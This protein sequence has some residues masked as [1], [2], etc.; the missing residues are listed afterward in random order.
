M[1]RLPPPQVAR[2]QLRRN[3]KRQKMALMAPGTFKRD[4]LG[5][6]GNIATVITSILV[7]IVVAGAE[8]VRNIPKIPDVAYATFND[9]L[10]QREFDRNLTGKWTTRIPERPGAPAFEMI[11]EMETREGQ[12][13]AMMTTHASIPWSHSEFTDVK[14]I[15]KG[16]YLELEFWGFVL[17][18]RKTFARSRIRIVPIP[19]P[20]ICED[21]SIDFSNLTMETYWQSLPVLPKTLQ[22]KKV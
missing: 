11:L 19:C 9:Y 8:N 16:E 6:V 10:R 12:S 17:G 5:V 18:K 20:T 2:V 3:R 4:W 7:A 1:R 21:E 15:A 13:G 14:V 22:L